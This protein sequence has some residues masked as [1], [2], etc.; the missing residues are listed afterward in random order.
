[1]RALNPVLKYPGAKW[2]LSEWIISNIPPHTTYLEPFFGSGAI[3]FNKQPSYRETI[4]DLNKQVVNLFKVIREQPEELAWRIEFSPWSRDEYR[5]CY[6]LTGVPLEDA[7]RFLVRCWQ[8]FGTKLN[9]S[10][11]W[12]NDIQGRG[13]GTTKVWRNIPNRILL[14]AERLKNA[15]IEN[16]PALQLIQRYNYP[17][18]LIYADPPYVLSTR[19]DKMYSD[20]MTDNDHIELLKALDNHSGFVLLSGY[21]SQLYDEYLKHWTRKTTKAIAERGLE[22]EEVLW[23]NPRTAN[24][25]K[26][27]LF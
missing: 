10:T 8:A 19:H 5:E 18:V 11:G 7:R 25:I 4:N 9:V 3:F 21:A 23:I 14:V 24:M 2:N 27:S 6:N 13:P 16:Q 20:E 1:M 15:Q 17:E 26:S 12:R 22:R